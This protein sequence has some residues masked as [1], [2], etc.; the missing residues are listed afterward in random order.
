MIR[1]QAID[2]LARR[3]ALAAALMAACVLVLTA[4]ASWWLVSRQQNEASQVLLEKEAQLNATLLKTTTGAILARVSEASESSLLANALVD[5]AGRQT[6]L[7]PYLNGM[8]RIN[9]IALHLLFADFEGKEIASSSRANFS[10]AQLAWLRA[11]LHNGRENSAIFP[12]SNGD[13]LLLVE[14]LTYARTQ[15]PEGALLYKVRLADLQAGISGQLRWG[16]PTAQ[17]AKAG[18]LVLPL[19]LAPRLAKHHLRL[20]QSERKSATDQTGNKLVSILL[21]LTAALVLVGAVLFLGLRLAPALTRDLRELEAF[22][23]SVVENGFGGQRANISGSVEV[24]GLARSINHMLDRLYQQHSRLQHES[25]E[26][27]RLLVEGTNAISWE[28]HWPDQAFLFVS[29][30][31]QTIT[32]IAA[33]RWLEHQF[34]SRHLHPDEFDAVLAQRSNAVASRGNYRCEYR[35]LCADGHYLWLEEIASVLEQEPEDDAAG[36]LRLRGILLDI[37][38]RKQTEA[39]LAEERNKV[40][41]LKNEFVSIVSHELRTPLTSIRGSLGLILGGVAGEVAPNLRKLL[42]IAHVNSERLVRLINDLLDIDKIA[43]GKMDFNLQWLDLLPLVEQ[44]LEANQAYAGQLGVRLVLLRGIEGIKVKVD[45][46]R[47]MQVMANLLSNAAKFSPKEGVVELAMHR[48]EGR[49]RVEVIDHGG[50]IS[51]EFQRK[52]FQKFSQED[53]SSTR[54]KGGTGLGLS[55]SKAL[56]EKMGGEIGFTTR[57][58][59]GSTFYFD[60]PL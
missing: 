49:V 8:Q 22:S 17:E 9:G 27:Y 34:W 6:Y 1:N 44:A 54:A 57:P 16:K 30:Q 55:I 53:S 52:I 37:D 33:P 4:S 45:Q 23:R 26:R 25:E 28:A 39:R 40:D 21:L 42:D 3:F 43:S 46:D 47:L 7:I 38:E 2:T 29:P 36:G 11:H 19:D 32:G 59:A 50:G 5:S 35:F 60:L 51:E 13:E 12:G 24:V 58:G 10:S 41:R 14:L 15:T 31:A 18:V 20:I 56:I 48:F